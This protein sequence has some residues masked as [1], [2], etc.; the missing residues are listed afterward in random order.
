MSQSERRNRT[1]LIQ[2]RCTPEEHDMI[3]QSAEA[4]C[5][6]VAEYVRRI[7][8][9]RKIKPVTDYKMIMELSRL[10]GLQKHLFMQGHRADSKEYAEI[11]SELKKA[12]LRVD[13]VLPRQGYD[14]A[15]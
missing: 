4:A 7:A 1:R 13:G 9:R 5:L 12:I 6:T 11:L 10:G 8:L 14:P 15:E 3:L 2:V